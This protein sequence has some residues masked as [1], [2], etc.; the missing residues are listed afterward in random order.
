MVPSHVCERDRPA[1]GRRRARRGRPEEQPGALI[2]LTADRTGTG[3]PLVLLHG[4]GESAALPAG[5]TPTA[6]ALADAV[7]Q[8]VSPS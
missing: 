1:Q 3:E 6:E 2:T 8:A 5:V 4:A 7:E